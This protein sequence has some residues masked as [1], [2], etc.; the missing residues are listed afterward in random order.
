[1]DVRTA[2][3]ETLSLTVEG[4]SAQPVSVASAGYDINLGDV[5]V[6][7]TFA[8][9]EEVDGL[10]L[11]R[12]MTSTIDRFPQYDIRVTANTVDDEPG[13]LAAPAG[14]REA[15]VPPDVPPATVTV[16][17][18]GKGLWRLAGQGHHSVLIEFADHLT[19]IEVPT[20]EPRTL[21]VIA[22]A[23]ELVPGKPLTHAIV[24]HHHFDH[25]AG[26]RAAVSEGLTII[27]H[28][29][30]E[31]LF[32]EIVGRRHSI[33]EDA[34]ARNP[35]PLVFQAVTEDVTLKDDA[36]EALIFHVAGSGH[37]E[38]LLATYFPREQLLVQ[39]D[40]FGSGY[41]TFPF[42]ANLN[43]NIQKRGLRVRR[44]VP[45]HGTPLGQADL[46]KVVADPTRPLR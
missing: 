44:H 21:A 14:I 26:L 3:G 31:K 4:E 34:L 25:A 45:I 24:T 6:V 15:A 30:T 43:E 13:D 23:R 16:E 7:T 40:V 36:N 32:A 39:A 12:R 11:P 9:Y 20:N 42:A 46:L 28:A 27:A 38:T 1:V 33:V 22:K 35:K 29:R 41:V 17:E 19:L 37:A 5:Q 2:A 10:R 8:D 18:L